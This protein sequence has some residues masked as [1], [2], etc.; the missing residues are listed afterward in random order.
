MQIFEHFIYI[1]TP[2]KSWIER[3]LS[4]DERWTRSHRRPIHLGN[5]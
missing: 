4:I 2:S 3:D 5:I 1:W